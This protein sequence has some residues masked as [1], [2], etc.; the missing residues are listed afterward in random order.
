MFIPWPEG[1]PRPIQSPG[2]HN[3]GIDA[4]LN[5]LY[6]D[7]NAYVCFPPL[8]VS[9]NDRA[10]STIQTG[11][12]ATRPTPAP[13]APQPVGI[14]RAARPGDQASKL[15]PA[16]DADAFTNRC[17]ELLKLNRR[18]EA[19]AHFEKALSLR[20]DDLFALASR[21][22]ILFDLG[23]YDAALV[24]CDQ[25]LLLRPNDAQALNMR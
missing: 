2:I 5:S 24:N 11:G 9:P 8:V 3:I 20:P 22:N 1:V 13:S 19:L 10:N 23:R 25:L 16:D 17:V 18:E 14:I 6:R 4:T 12:A 7:L 21:G 15:Q